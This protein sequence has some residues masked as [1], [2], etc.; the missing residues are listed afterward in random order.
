MADAAHGAAGKTDDPELCSFQAK[1]I[2]ASPPVSLQYDRGE[3]APPADMNTRWGRALLSL[4]G[5][6]GD[7]SR[8]NQ[9]RSGE[10]SDA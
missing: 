8:G 2:I 6:Y 9:G 4:F 10:L 7:K 3:F 5:F 1:E